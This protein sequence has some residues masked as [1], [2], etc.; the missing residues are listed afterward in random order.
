MLEGG[1]WRATLI[2]FVGMMSGSIG[3]VP[4]YEKELMGVIESESDA[5]RKLHEWKLLQG[6]DRV[7]RSLSL[8]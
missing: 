7:L 2:V 3:K 6:Q 1:E 8:Y 5:I 4:Q